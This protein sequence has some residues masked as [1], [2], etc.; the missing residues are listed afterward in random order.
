MKHFINITSVGFK[1]GERVQFTIQRWVEDM[2]DTD[3]IWKEAADHAAHWKV[4]FD[5]VASIS[6]CSDY[7]LS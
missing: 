6:E 7:R 5:H 1:G 3:V 4:E 2:D